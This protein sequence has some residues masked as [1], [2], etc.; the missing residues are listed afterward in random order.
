MT[1]ISPGAARWPRLLTER[2]GEAAPPKLWTL[3]T[4]ICSP[5]PKPRCSVPPPGKVI[6]TTYDQAAKWRDAGR[7]IVSGF[8]S[9][10]EKECLQIL[11]RGSQPIIICPPLL[12]TTLGYGM[13]KAPGQRTVAD[14]PVSTRANG[15]SPPISPPAATN[16]SPRWLTKSGSLTSPPAG[17]W[18]S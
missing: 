18:Q 13:A 8:H 2:L 12:A 3:A 9:P 7:C 17:T 5:C 16:S 1:C 4:A 11:L 15:A 10:V 14:P 6:L